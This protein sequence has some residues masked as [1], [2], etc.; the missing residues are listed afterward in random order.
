M[1]T[2]GAGA[3]SMT[4]VLGNANLTAAT[5]DQ[6]KG[7]T[8]GSDAIKLVAD[9][10]ALGV[11]TVANYGE[12]SYAS[13]DAF[14]TGANGANKDVWVGQVGSDSFVAVDHNSDG[15][16]DYAIELVGVGLS[17]VAVDSFTF[18]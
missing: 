2:G 1:I 5:A 12:A 3:D 4:F 17:G 9:G 14:L 15:T 10:A 8:Y 7:Y 18:V 11:L 13:F 16:V 6:I